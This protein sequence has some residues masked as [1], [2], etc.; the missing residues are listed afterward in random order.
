MV[1]RLFRL[2]VALLGAAFRGSMWR[3]VRTGLGLLVLFALIVAAAAAPSFLGVSATQRAMIDVLA[4]AVVLAATFVVPFFANR[5]NLSPAQFAS[6]PASAGSIGF[7]LF[8]TTIFSWPFLIFAAW[9]ISLGVF[10]TEWQ[11]AGWVLPAAL[12][13]AALLGIAC[14][15]VMAALS[16]RIA[17]VRYTGALRT[18]GVVLLVACVPFAVLAGSAT[19]TAAGETAAA[20]AARIAGLTPFGAPFAAIGFAA[21]GD[22]DAALMHLGLAV[23]AL[24]VL[25]LLWIPLVRVTLFRVDRPADPGV[26]RR[27]LGWFE[28]FS[29]RPAQVIAARS[30]T[31]WSRDPRYRVALFAIPIA[32]LVMIVAFS[33]AGA[34]MRNL[35]LVPLPVVLLLLAWS[36]HNDVAM[37]STAIWEHVASG[38]RGRSDRAG[39]LAPVMMIGVPLAVIGSSL[40]VTVAGEWR[41]LP[42]VL[43]LNIAVLLVASGIT[44][45]FSVAMPYPTTRPG[46]SPFVQPQWSGSGS[47][48]AQTLSMLVSLVLAVPPVWFAVLAIIDLSF[49]ENMWALAFGVGYGLVVLVLGI[50]IG[51]KLFER[52]GPELIAVTQVFD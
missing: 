42:A 21:G 31:Y 3:A 43:G 49:L 7:G 29:A 33:V 11:G 52:N 37:D 48:L 16:Q 27:G 20:E 40:T 38:I 8:I 44:S 34:D 51:G 39:R 22:T 35:A 13:V 25:L 32:P 2:R 9:L 30:L 1:A 19:L 10:R 23:G 6:Y 4:G 41:I 36:Q 5:R 15:R 26:A 12:V 45:I 50:L 24:I 46:D 28:R 47:G 17:G 14:V 18:I